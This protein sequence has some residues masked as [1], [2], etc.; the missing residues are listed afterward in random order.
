VLEDKTLMPR[1][2]VPKKEVL[3]PQCGAA[4]ELT[5][6]QR[7]SWFIFASWTKCRA[8]GNDILIRNNVPTIPRDRDRR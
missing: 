2:R 6:R 8:C 7:R 5:P 4:L 3:C 1:N